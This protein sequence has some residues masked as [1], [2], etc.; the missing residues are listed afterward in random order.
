MRTL[1]DRSEINTY[2]Q[3]EDFNIECFDR[4]ND[5]VQYTRRADKTLEIL[6]NLKPEA[7]KQLLK[8]GEL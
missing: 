6:P 7:L 1:P 3:S 5:W 8:N 4:L 2:I